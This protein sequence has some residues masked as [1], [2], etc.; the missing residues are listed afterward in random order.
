MKFDVKDAPLE[1]KEYI[2]TS[3]EWNGYLFTPK[4]NPVTGDV[5]KYTAKEKNLY[6]T[7]NGYS[8]NVIITGSPH[9]YAH[10]HN[11]SPFTLS[12]LSDTISEIDERW[13]GQ[14][15]TGK[16]QKFEFGVNVN[17]CERLVDE[18]VSLKHKQ[19]NLIHSKGKTYGAIVEFQDFTH[20]H[21]DKGLEQKL[22]YQRNIDFKVQR[23]ETKYSRMKH[24]QSRKNGIAIYSPSDLTNYNI[25]MQVGQDFINKIKA[26]HYVSKTPPPNLKSNDIR[27]IAAHN[28]DWYSDHMKANHPEAYKKERRKYLKNK[29]QMDS[30]EY[31]SEIEEVETTLDIMLTS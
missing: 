27:V 12:Q 1:A 4:Y 3:F 19:F 18:V 13:E 26:S 5:L 9:V 22:H 21:Y 29:K 24:L 17:H 14:Y 23:L 25:M 28:T 31:K 20:K 11:Y 16:L 7:L 2:S 6:L 15:S 30:Y 10:G 8:E